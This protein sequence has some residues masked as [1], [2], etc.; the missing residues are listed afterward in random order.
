[1]KKTSIFSILAVFCMIMIS[2]GGSSKSAAEASADNAVSVDEVLANADNM[3]GDTIVVE[4]VCSHLC[5]HGGKKAFIA[6]AADSIM[7]R[8]EAFPLM[9]EPFPKSVVRRPMQVK[10]IL[11]EERV[12]EAAIQEMIR[13]NEEAQAAAAAKAA[14]NGDLAADSTATKAESGCATE[15]TAKGQRNLVTFE[16]RIN[17]FRA[18]IAA[19]HEKEGKPYLSYYYLEAISYDVLPE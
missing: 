6:G 12:D 11:R 18:K 2:C 17:D 9:G 4:G 1:M 5:A 14:E 16:D 19:R 3:L 13:R 15:R 7:L 10:G 8:C